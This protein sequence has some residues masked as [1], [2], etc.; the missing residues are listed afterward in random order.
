MT[1]RS[2]KTLGAI[3]LVTAAVFAATGADTG[4]CKNDGI[5]HKG[6]VKSRTYDKR[7]KQYRLVI[8]DESTGRTTFTVTRNE[9][10]MCSPGE[11]YPGCRVK[12]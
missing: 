9:Y 6:E 11:Y 10:N 8:D 7:L 12:F 4:G 1:K 2:S 3:A 5:G